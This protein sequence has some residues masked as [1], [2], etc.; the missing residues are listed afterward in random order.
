MR[1]DKD[2]ESNAPETEE[3]Q[4]PV[5]STWRGYG[6]SFCSQPANV[7]RYEVLI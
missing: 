1:E 6:P 4:A 3:L 5:E 7:V 2:D